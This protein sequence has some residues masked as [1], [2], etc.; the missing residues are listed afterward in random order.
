[1]AGS[2]GPGAGRLRSSGLAQRKAQ[3]SEPGPAGTTVEPEVRPLRHR[4]RGIKSSSP[5]PDKMPVENT[6]AAAA[7]SEPSGTS[8]GPPDHPIE[9]KAGGRRPR[10][11]RRLFWV[12]AVLAAVVVVLRIALWLSLPWIMNKTM[13]PYGLE[14]HYERLNLSLLTGD[15]ELWHLALVSTDANTPL[16]DVEYCRAEVSLLTL[17]TRRLVVP[18]IEI[19]GMDVSL[20]R[21]RD[22]TFPQLRT[23]LAVLRERIAAAEPAD[24]QAVSTPASPRALDLT[25]PLQIDAMRLQH[26]QVHFQDN[27]VTPAFETRLDLNVR[28]SDLRSDKRKTRFQ[29]ILSSPPVLDQLLVEGIGSSDGSDVL[30]DVKVALQGLHPGAVKDYL[31]DLGLVPDGQNLALACTGSVRIQGNRMGEANDVDSQ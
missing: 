26:V 23:L 18:R 22:G 25:P 6:V 16:T 27:S 20:T 3:R 2:E 31:A 17:L 11:L 24:A 12:F 21:A 30:A 4:K 14:A 5:S 15:A 8:G 29:V 9:R 19:D 10:W 13:A 7:G 1:M 28:L